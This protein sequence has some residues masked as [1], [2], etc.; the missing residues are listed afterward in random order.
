[1]V[2][3]PCDNCPFLR[4]KVEAFAL[5]RA[6]KREIANSLRKGGMFPCHKTVDYSDSSSG[7]TTSKSKW[8]AGALA[9][10]NNEDP[11]QGCMSNQMARISARLG[12]FNPDE[13]QGAELVFGSLKE[14]EKAD[15]SR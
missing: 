11:E 1:V 8:C 3:R 14:W 13:L 15:G 10:M 6:R 9:T 7:R 12:M 4:A 2:K 5:P